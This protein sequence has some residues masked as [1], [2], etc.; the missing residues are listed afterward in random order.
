MDE[1]NRIRTKKKVGYFDDNAEGRAGEPLVEQCGDDPR[2]RF[3]LVGVNRP[4]LGSGRGEV[5]HIS[6]VR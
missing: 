1:L 6:N 4:E 3:E 5:G 2:T